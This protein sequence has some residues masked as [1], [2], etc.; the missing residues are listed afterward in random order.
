[1]TGTILNHVIAQGRYIGPIIE[2]VTVQNEDG[3]S[4]AYHIRY[5][6]EVSPNSGWFL[7]RDVRFIKALEGAV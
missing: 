6:R 5:Q 3:Y 4:F 2:M 1:M 7:D